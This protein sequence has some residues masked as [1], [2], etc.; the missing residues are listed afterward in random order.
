MNKWKAAC[1]ILAKQNVPTLGSWLWPN[2]VCR[3]WPVH[4]QWRRQVPHQM[5]LSWGRL[6]FFVCSVFTGTLEYL[7]TVEPS[8]DFLQDWFNNQENNH[9][10][11]NYG[12]YSSKSDVWSYGVVMWE[13]MSGGKVP[14]PDYTNHQVLIEWFWSSINTDFLTKDKR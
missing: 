10:V 6:L 2:E 11:I 1:R 12:K 7:I 3:W 5:E 9:Q 13:I 4:S 8:W 14:Y